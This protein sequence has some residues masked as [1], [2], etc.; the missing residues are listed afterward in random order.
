M[1]IAFVFSESK[2]TA[3]NGGTSDAVDSTGANLIVIGIHR[4]TTATLTVSD[5][6][7]NTYTALTSYQASGMA[8][9]RWYYCLAPTVGSGHTFTIAGT[10]VYP[11][12]TAMGFSG[13]KTS[14]PFDA[15]NGATG[16][17]GTSR[18]PGSVTPAEN[19]SLIIAGMAFNGAVTSPSVNSSMTLQEN[20]PYL[21]SNYMGALAA[22]YIQPTATAIN[23]TFSWTTS[24]NN[25]SA[26]C[27]F[28]P[29]PAAGT[30]SPH[31]YYSQQRIAS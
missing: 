31:Y 23:P 7:G 20:A 27:V 21:A 29:E 4:Y 28:K 17:N 10:G 6:K 5:S 2:G 15:E 1:A 11:T 13:V 14:S 3:I 25:S 19:G 22:Y 12:I 26:I 30:G 18:Q 8:G 9:I 16:A 24:V